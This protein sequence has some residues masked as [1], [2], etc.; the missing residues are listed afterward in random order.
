[1]TERLKKVLDYIKANYYSGIQV[2]CSRNTVGDQMESVWSEDGVVIDYCP[3]YDYL[4]VLGL[5][6]D[7]IHALCD[8]LGDFSKFEFEEPEHEE[9]EK[10]EVEEESTNKYKDFLD[11]IIHHVENLGEGTFDV[12]LDE[13]ICHFDGYYPAGAKNGRFFVYKGFVFMLDIPEVMSCD[14]GKFWL[15]YFSRRFRIDQAPGAEIPAEHAMEL[16]M[17]LQWAWAEE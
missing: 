17:T 8:L 10:P 5:T 15:F 13:D 2:F 7:E 11:E 3:Y 6:E 1:M 4:E 16:M 9:P 12:A 14:D